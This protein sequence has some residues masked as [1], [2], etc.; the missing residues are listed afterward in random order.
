[1][2]DI[3]RDQLLNA[4]TTLIYEDFVLPNEEGTFDRLCP[5]CQAHHALTTILSLY[6]H[7]DHDDDGP[8]AEA[9]A[10]QLTRPKRH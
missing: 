3:K 1:M 5:H 10:D 7:L 6:D 9:I 4:R 2:S 8:D